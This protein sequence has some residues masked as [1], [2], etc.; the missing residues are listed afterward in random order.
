MRLPNTAHTGRPWR[1]HQLAQDFTVLDVWQL[2]TPGGPDDFAELI[3]LIAS[4]D[5]S[6][7]SSRLSSALFAVRWK[8]GE[9]FGWDDDAA[10]AARGSTLRDRVPPD[11]ASSGRAAT[12]ALRPFSVVYETDD[13]CAAE[14]VNKTV[15]GVLHLGWVEDPAGGYRGQ[16]AVLVKPNG[17]LGRLYLAAIAP[18]RYLI[19][20]PAMLRSIARAWRGR[21]HRP[22]ATHA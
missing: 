15:H 10:S 13:E 2:P 1:I 6:H 9:L 7:G 8:L 18:F 21:D 5:F 12:A 22:A 4:G 3:D 16:M 17:R 11:L 20:Y 19:V 14:I